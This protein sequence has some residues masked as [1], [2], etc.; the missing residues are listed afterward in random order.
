MIIWTT[1]SPG[2]YQLQPFFMIF[3]YHFYHSHS[4]L[5]ITSMRFPMFSSTVP[6]G[7][8]H[9][10]QSIVQFPNP[11]HQLKS[12]F[13]KIAIYLSHY[14]NYTP[15]IPARESPSVRK[16]TYTSASPLIAR[17]KRS[18]WA[19]QTSSLHT[20]STQRE[21][22]TYTQFPPSV[23]KQSTTPTPIMW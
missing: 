19:E 14:Y 22:K 12:S 18:S 7:Y 3:F 20:W 21:P 11:H 16:H 23:H 5:L 15:G 8:W 4:W 9:N 2:F 17:L 6:A 13:V 10:E 1:I